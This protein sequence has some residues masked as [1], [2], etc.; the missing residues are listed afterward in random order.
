MGGVLNAGVAENANVSGPFGKQAANAVGTIIFGGGILQYSAVNQFDYSGRFSTAANQV[1]GIDTNGQNVT[2]GTALTSSGGTLTKL[3][4]GTLTLNTAG[5][6]IGNLNVNGGALSLAGG[7]LTVTNSWS[8]GFQVGNGTGTNGTFNLSGGTLGVVALTIGTNGGTGFFNQTGGT[9]NATGFFSTGLNATTGSGIYRMGGG[10]FSLAGGL[11]LAETTGGTCAIYQT[12]GTI[13]A[14]NTDGIYLGRSTGGKGIIA[15]TGGTFTDNAVDLRVGSGHSGE[16]DVGGT[17][18]VIVGATNAAFALRVEG[19][20]GGTGIVNQGGGT[21]TV[22]PGSTNGVWLY[23]G[24]TSAIYNLNGGTLS[25][26][27]ILAAGSNAPQF[28]FGGGTLTLNGAMT[29]N[30]PRALPPTS[31]LAGRRSI[32]MV[33]TALGTRPCSPVRPTRSPV[34]PVWSAAADTLRN[35]R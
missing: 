3:G 34:F 5:N 6:S 17:G 8:N 9:I 31:T 10:T 33:L 32:P 21:V 7:T 18:S 26:A 13:T 20:N 11:S 12:G 29:V 23:G 28:N 15:L 16:L 4:T 19:E 27:K 22:Q 1:I 14:G 35:P 2:F 24:G 30:T 25:A